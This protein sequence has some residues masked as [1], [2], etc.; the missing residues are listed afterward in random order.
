[1]TFKEFDK[2][3]GELSCPLC[4]SP[5]ELGEEEAGVCSHY[6]YFNVEC[7]KCSFAYVDALS[8][9]KDTT[10]EEIQNDFDE[11]VEALTKRCNG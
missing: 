3:V 1:M 11:L 4:C 6:Q 2:R 7:T 8:L 9:S 10:E 5:L